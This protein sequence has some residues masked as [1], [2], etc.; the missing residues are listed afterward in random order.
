[1][2]EL[3]VF[4]AL[5]LGLIYSLLA[6]GIMI[7]YRILGIADLTV[8][9]SFTTGAAVCAVFT[10]R[11]QPH[12]GILLAVLASGLAGACSALLQTKLRIQPILA[13]ILTMTALYSINLHI[14]G[15][16][17][18]I[19]LLGINHLFSFLKTTFPG[20]KAV[21]VVL[22][23]I[24]VIVSVAL[25]IFFKTRLGLSIR[26]TGDNETMVRTSSINSDMT[27]IVGLT[28]SNGVVGLSGAL[29]SQYQGFADISLGVGMV[30]VALASLIIGELILGRK[31]VT[32]NIIAVVIG[33]V[34]Y[35]LLLAVILSFSFNPSDIKLISAAIVAVAI[36][37][38][39]LKKRISLFQRKRQNQRE[40]KSD[41]E[42]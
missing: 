8:E 42:S 2:S 10:L 20:Q 12:W 37:I 29:L 16:K 33:A 39:L 30:V 22:L 27:K 21:A 4:G 35:R 41:V 23:L 11:G 31:S 5:E 19:S 25:A 40:A 1:M 7:S 34:L 24:V 36:S 14:M 15:G 17:A 6:L 28:L 26:A 3:A 38:P 9:G 13:G 32:R 18:N